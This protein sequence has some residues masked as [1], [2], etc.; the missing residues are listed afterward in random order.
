MSR[1]L[2]IYESLGGT[3]TE[4]DGIFYPDIIFCDN[5]EKDIWVGKYGL[6]WIDYIK[7]NEPDRYRNLFHR[8]R[9][10]RKALEVNSEAY[11]MLDAIM[12]QY[13]TEYRFK[14]DKSTMEIW[15]VREQ[16]KQMAEE[17]V[18]QDVVFHYH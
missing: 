1:E 17:M 15:K 5:E 2:S 6:I 3:Y 8:G 14:A 12:N 4:M 18:L 7:S 11:E 9:L 10:K 13:L 16:A